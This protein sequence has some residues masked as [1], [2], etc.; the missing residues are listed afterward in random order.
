M[1]LGTNIHHVSENCFKSFTRS[2][3][4][5]QGHSETKFTFLAE[6]YIATVWRRGSLVIY[7]SSFRE[8]RRQ[9][10]RDKGLSVNT[11]KR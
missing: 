6:A 1:K 5:G 3:V 9:P 2:E 7:E 8:N 4:K 11:F 10:V